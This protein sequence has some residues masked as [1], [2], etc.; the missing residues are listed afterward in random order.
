VY[1]PVGTQRNG[2]P[3]LT[4]H[5]LS[6]CRLSNDKGKN[7]A[8]HKIMTMVMALVTVQNRPEDSAT[9][10]RLRCCVA[11]TRDHKVSLPVPCPGARRV[12]CLVTPA[13]RR[14]HIVCPALWT[15]RIL[16]A[17]PHRIPRPYSRP[18][19]I[20]FA[21]LAS[22]LPRFLENTP[23]WWKKDCLHGLPDDILM[24][25]MREY[26]TLPEVL[27][28][29]QVRIFLVPHR[30]PLF[31]L[32]VCRLTD[33]CTVLHVRRTSGNNSLRSI[34]DHFLRSHPARHTRLVGSARSRRSGCSC[35]AYQPTTTS[36]ARSRVCT[37]R[38]HV[39]RSATCTSSSSC[40]AGSTCSPARA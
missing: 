24:H 23:R 15:T 8:Q 30:F 20:M 17:L 28:L 35:A 37:V 32:R 12:L 36:D 22:H 14:V 31:Y 34:P 9:A 3:R 1:V 21:R 38:R 5:Y 18:A 10:G 4:S 7:A 16:L 26:F 25:I 27:H 40:P 19:D 33:E 6:I 29:R 39:R 13:S 11:R 2:T